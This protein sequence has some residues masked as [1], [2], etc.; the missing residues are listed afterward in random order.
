MFSGLTTTRLRLRPLE[1]ADT[2]ALYSYRSDPQV[3]EFQVWEPQD[4]NEVRAFIERNQSVVFNAPDTWYQLAITLKEDGTLI[5]DC[6]LNFSKDEGQIEL[7]ITLAPAY[8]GHGYATEA[9][10][11]ILDYVF[12]TLDKHRV[13]ARIDP[14]NTPSI[15]LMKRLG[16]RKEGHLRECVWIKGE[17]ADDVIYAILKQEWMASKSD[18][19]A[20][21]SRIN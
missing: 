18:H 10:A 11:G 9:L 14:E 17:W 7:G 13:Y 16:M 5:G 2:A 8:Q 3:R 1:I 6:G 21:P 19:T 20:Q 4:E 15:T 12:M